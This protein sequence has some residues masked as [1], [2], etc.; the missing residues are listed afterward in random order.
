MVHNQDRKPFDLTPGTD[1]TQAIS[2]TLLQGLMPR[3][4]DLID[5]S[6][7]T[8]EQINLSGAN[9]YSAGMPMYVHVSLQRICE[10]NQFLKQDQQLAGRLTHAVLSSLTF[11]RNDSNI[12]SLLHE[13][14]LWSKEEIEENIK[15]IEYN[16]KYHNDNPEDHRSEIRTLNFLTDDDQNDRNQE[17]FQDDYMERLNE[18]RDKFMKMEVSSGS[19]YETPKPEEGEEKK[20]DDRQP[21]TPKDDDDEEPDYDD[22]EGYQEEEAKEMDV[23]ED[24]NEDDED[25]MMQIVIEQSIKEEKKEEK[26][27][28]VLPAIDDDDEVADDK[29]EEP[30]KV[31]ASPSAAPSTTVVEPQAAVTMPS[32][33]PTAEPEA[34]TT[35]TTEE[36]TAVPQARNVTS[37]G[38][39]DVPPSSP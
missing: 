23:E 4:M 13:M 3:E 25:Q 8:E 1:V 32:A 29:P 39:S 9:A 21:Q 28:D 16:N 17:Q 36:T 11:Q 10:C 19:S 2:P 5:I 34:A 14:A 18:E 37:F 33:A 38:T 22:Q 30:P 12:R 31:E 15:N 7:L 24:E 35:T 6:Q 26:K 27:D 20:E